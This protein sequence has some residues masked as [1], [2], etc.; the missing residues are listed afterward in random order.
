MVVEYTKEPAQLIDFCRRI[1][2]SSW[3]A[4]DTEF[5]HEKHILVPCVAALLKN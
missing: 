3:L 2:D 5:F 1:A 4:I